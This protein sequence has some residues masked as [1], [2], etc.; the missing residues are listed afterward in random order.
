MFAR[1]L[2]KIFNQ[3]SQKLTVCQLG[4]PVLREIAQPIADVR[5]RDIQQLIDQMLITLKESKGVGLAAPQIGRS[6]QLVVIASHPNER[7]PHAPQMEPTA[8]INLKLISP[9]MATS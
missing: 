5:D 9:S 4:N 3:K 1:S 6:L 2:N 8:M 7:Y